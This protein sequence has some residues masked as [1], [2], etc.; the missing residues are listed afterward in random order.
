MPEAILKLGDPM[1]VD[2]VRPHHPCQPQL[3]SADI[4]SPGCRPGT[5]HFAAQPKAQAHNAVHLP[6]LLTPNGHEGATET[7]C[8]MQLESKGDRIMVCEFAGIR[9]EMIPTLWS[10]STALIKGAAARMHL[11][12]VR[13]HRTLQVCVGVAARLGTLRGHLCSQATP[14]AAAP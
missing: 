12:P 10:W 5:M 11:G 8:V 6:L 1:L 7:R 3:K 4:A 13:P 14:H 2:Q 9:D